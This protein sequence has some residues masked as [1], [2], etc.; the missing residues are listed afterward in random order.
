MIVRD[1]GE[2]AGRQV[3]GQAQ[4]H[5]AA[6]GWAGFEH[7]RGVY[8]QR[9]CKIRQAAGRVKRWAWGFAKAGSA[10]ARPTKLDGGA[11]LFRVRARHP[12]PPPC[13]SSA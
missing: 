10:A 5:E 7:G 13:V 11:G 9:I 4:G 12:A 2:Q 3:R 1:G 8:L 6:T